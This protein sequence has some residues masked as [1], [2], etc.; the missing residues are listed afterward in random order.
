MD[1][2]VSDH[3]QQVVNEVVSAIGMLARGDLAACDAWCAQIVGLGVNTDGAGL[4]GAARVGGCGGGGGIGYYCDKRK[5]AAHLLT[6][7]VFTH[8]P[9]LLSKRRPFRAVD[10]M[11]EEIQLAQACSWDSKE[12]LVSAVIATVRLG[13]GGRTGGEK[14]STPGDEA[15]YL[16]TGYYLMGLLFEKG[17]E[18]PGLL[19]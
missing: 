17:L 19:L 16:G 2:D 14:L 8:A 4:G 5:C 7:C 1:G 9:S 18:Q 15:L 12:V 13:G 10:T 3:H 6:R 11:T